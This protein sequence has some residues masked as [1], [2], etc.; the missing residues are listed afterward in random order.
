MTTSRVTQLPAGAQA[1][2]SLRDFHL[3]TSSPP[4]EWPPPTDLEVYG[5]PTP[6][7]QE[8]VWVKTT[9]EAALNHRPGPW[10]LAD[11]YTPSTSAD[12]SVVATLPADARKVGRIGTLS[13]LYTTLPVGVNPAD[14]D[15][16][17]IVDARKRV[18]AVPYAIAQKFGRWTPVDGSVQDRVA[19][20]TPQAIPPRLRSR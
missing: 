18:V 14:D 16:V 7:D 12:S 10:R 3:F 15:I 1:I 17:Y 8:H 19:T 6:D 9:L 11:G 13:E 4:A 5:G 2:L 20:H